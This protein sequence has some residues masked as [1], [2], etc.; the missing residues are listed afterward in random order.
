[1]KRFIQPYFLFN[2]PQFIKAIYYKFRGYP[3]NP[4]YMS[5]PW[6]HRIKS[7]GTNDFIGHR[8]FMHGIIATEA[9]EVAFRLCEPGDTAIDVGAN[10]GVVTSAL[11]QSV[12]KEGT[13]YSFEANPQT[14]QSLK[15]NVK[16][17]RYYNSIKTTNC[18]ISDFEGEI[19][20][21]FSDNSETNS[22][23][24]FV[25]QQNVVNSETA[26]SVNQNEI[27]RV[28]KVACQTLDHFLADISFI[29]LLKIDVERHEYYVLK[30]TI[31]QLETG[32]IENIFFEDVSDGD[33]Q[34]KQLLW[35]HN[36]EIY[37]VQKGTMKLLVEKV[38]PSGYSLEGI[39][40]DYSDFIAT[41]NSQRLL[42]N[43]SQL[44]YKCF[45]VSKLT[46]V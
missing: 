16:T 32:N 7:P 42:K 19:N 39:S 8:L 29:R 2:P 14:Y 12:G 45:L 18:A 41:L 6:Q 36:Y 5:L 35:S 20:L 38:T 21:V 34:S 27:K 1:M 3:T 11:A 40:N 30:G 43:F 23:V 44:G 46:R 28:E 33:T 37:S 9:C 22:G 4:F 15:N 17:H 25:T 26:K 24:V 13:V 31:N 10:I